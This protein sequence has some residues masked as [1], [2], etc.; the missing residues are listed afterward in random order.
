MK[1][2]NS[3]NSSL[4]NFGVI[5]LVIDVMEGLEDIVGLVGVSK[6]H[7]ALSMIEKIIPE[8]FEQNKEIISDLIDAFAYISKHRKALRINEKRLLKTILKCCS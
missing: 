5:S 8:T 6:K 3:R 2:H 7:K 4:H 1:R